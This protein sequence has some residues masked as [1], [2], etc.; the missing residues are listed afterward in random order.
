MKASQLYALKPIREEFDFENA[1]NAAKKITMESGADYPFN[2]IFNDERMDYKDVQA[3]DKEERVKLSY[4]ME[5]G[6]DKYGAILFTVRFDDKP[7]M[8][9]QKSGRWYDDMDVFLT[10]ESI[11]KEFEAYIVEK[12]PLLPKDEKLAV[13]DPEKDLDYLTKIGDYNMADYYDP[14]LNPLY[15]K[16]D[17]VWGWTKENHLKYDFSSDYKG[18]VLTKVEITSV[19]PTHPYDTYSGIQIERSWNNDE[20]VLSDKGGIG[21]SLND[22][23]IIGKVNEIDMPKLAINNLVDKEGKLPNNYNVRNPLKIK[24]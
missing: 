6:D 2:H 24:V 23:L 18:F 11:L 7:F 21:T 13:L 4:Y 17:I 8:I 14:T 12:F 1:V 16:G 15:E 22:S 19:N 20:M 9:V 10:D 5:E 3:I